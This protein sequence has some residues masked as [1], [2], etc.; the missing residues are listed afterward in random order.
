MGCAWGVTPPDS[1]RLLGQPAGAFGDSIGGGMMAGGVAAALFSR[2][3][4]GEA[5]S[6]MCP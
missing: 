4:T 5:Q 2:E 6:S 1:Q 3:R